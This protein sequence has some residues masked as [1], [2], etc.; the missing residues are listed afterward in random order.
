MNTP[1][2]GTFGFTAQ[3][4]LDN[5]GTG[6]STGA[7]VSI[8]VNPIADIPSVTT[9]TTAEDTQSTGGLVITRNLADG[10]EVTHFKITGITGGTLYKNDGT[11]V[12]NNNNYVTAA[13]GG[14]GLKYQ[15]FAGLE[16]VTPLAEPVLERLLSDQHQLSE[17]SINELRDIASRTHRLANK[18]KNTDAELLAELSDKCAVEA[19]IEGLRL[20]EAEAQSNNSRK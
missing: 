6:I 14:A 7:T 10:A 18:D 4:A 9:V 3:A 12:I 8:T 1:A 17:A 2:G 15:E 20:G 16:F 13:E 5:T 11:T 19:V